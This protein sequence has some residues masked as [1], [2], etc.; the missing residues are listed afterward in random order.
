MTCVASRGSLPLFVSLV[1]SPRTS[2]S[3]TKRWVSGESSLVGA[4]AR[5]DA[6]TEVLVLVRLWPRLLFVDC[7]VFLFIVSPPGAST[8]YVRIYGRSMCH[9]ELVASLAPLHPNERKTLSAYRAT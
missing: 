1:A 5:C 9:D 2:R 3:R 7:F 6:L 4:V 8:P